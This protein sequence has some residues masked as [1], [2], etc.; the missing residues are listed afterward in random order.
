MQRVT[1]LAATAAIAL[2]LWLTPMNAFGAGGLAGSGTASGPGGCTGPFRIQAATTDDVTWNI[3]VAYSAL[4]STTTAIGPFA[5]VAYVT[6][7]W[8]PNIGGSVSGPAGYVNIGAVRIKGSFVS[9]SVSFC[10]PANTCYNGNAAV[11]RL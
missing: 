1:R 8:N 2:V 5:D 7:H 4:C 6:G 9:T 11:L 10:F 3:S